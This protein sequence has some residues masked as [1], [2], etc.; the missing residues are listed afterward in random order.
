MAQGYVVKTDQRPHA[1]IAD[2]TAGS[3]CGD[4]KRIG[5]ECYA[6]NMRGLITVG[7]KAVAGEYL[8]TAILDASRQLSG[9]HLRMGAY[10][11]PAAL[12]VGIWRKLLRHAAGWTGYT[13]A[14]RSNPHLKSILMA[15]ADTLDEAHEAA[16]KGWRYYRIRSVDDDG[17]AEPVAPGEAV[18][19]ASPE[20][21]H[22]MQ[23]I[24]CGS[25]AGTAVKGP[26][27]VIIDH[28]TRA[29][30]RLKVL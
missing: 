17:Q 8:E 14:W 26:H 11:D 6:T 16:A 27:R 7:R 9:Y 1:S 30:N 29:R 15:S 3:V 25:C 21:G 4:C 19:P 28:S 2:G 23:C 20:G 12:P 13:H 18:C 22:R 10:G 24:G 5:S